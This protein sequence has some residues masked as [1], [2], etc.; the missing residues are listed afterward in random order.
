MTEKNKESNV[1][2]IIPYK[3]RHN[4]VLRCLSS[5][6]SQTIKPFE[7]ILV[8]DGGLPLELNNEYCF[9]VVNI[10]NGKNYGAAYSRNVGAKYSRGDFLF[11]LDSDDEWDSSHISHIASI[12]QCNPYI[13]FFVSS[14]GKK[15]KKNKISK[16]KLSGDIV[17][18]SDPAEFQFLS[19]GSFRTSC[20]A[21][22]R[23]AFFSIG[24]FDEKQKK[25]QDWDLAF[26]YSKSS[27]KIIAASLNKTVLIDS[28][29]PERMSYNSNVDASLYF[30]KKHK[31]IMS[32][33]CQYAFLKGVFAGIIK[34]GDF[35]QLFSF[36][37]IFR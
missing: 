4:H 21:I 15:F 24:G 27:K 9:D 17:L 33:R 3:N 5:I 25:H 2:V 23:N 12:K 29:A 18:I 11:F 34:S 10:E 20:F 1:S 16:N 36:W 22:K 28:S 26:R 19:S 13:D 32:V 8:N 30:F 35:K 6:N 31:D 7:V 14:Y 37:M